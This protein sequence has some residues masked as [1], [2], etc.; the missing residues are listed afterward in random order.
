MKLRTADFEWLARSF[1]D[2]LHDAESNIVV[3]EIGFCAEYEPAQGKLRMGN[4]ADRDSS[5][6]LCDAFS[7]SIEL[8]SL[9][10][11]NWPSV[12]EVGG[13]HVDMA[14]RQ[15]IEVIDLHFFDDSR[16]CLG[17]RSGSEREMS[18]GRFMTELVVPF[19]YRLSYTDR[20]GLDAARDNL[21][22]DYSHGEEGFREYHREIL[23]IAGQAPGRND[24]CPCGS[25]RKYKRCHL[26]EVEQMRRVKLSEL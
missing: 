22:G 12:F 4:E 25:G 26:D 2:L 24:P 21:W 5:Y 15:A 18:I 17:I 9:D 7:I 11:N 23:S 8:D 1:P 3:G 13:R 10:S 6:F 16:C 20:Y 14:E 19:F